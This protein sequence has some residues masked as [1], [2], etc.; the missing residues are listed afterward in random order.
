MGDNSRSRALAFRKASAALKA[1]PEEIKKPEDVDNLYDIRGGAHCKGVILVRLLLE[2][3]L[4]LLF[5]NSGILLSYFIGQASDK[6]NWLQ[7]FL[8][9]ILNILFN[10]LNAF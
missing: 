8:T 4:E 3:F 5:H 2:L 6:C 9:N 7:N 1:L 10:F